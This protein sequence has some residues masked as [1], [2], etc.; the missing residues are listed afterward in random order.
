MAGELEQFNSVSTG[1]RELVDLQRQSLMEMKEI[2]QETKIQRITSEQRG[3][4]ALIAGATPLSG[5][6]FVPY[7]AYASDGVNFTPMPF[8]GA[9]QAM[10]N[11]ANAAGQQA[12][13]SFAD[14]LNIDST[15]TS[16]HMAT[17]M[18][19][20]RGQDLTNA[21]L[22]AGGAAF[23]SLAEMAGYA[24]GGGAGPI[25]S[26]IL[27][28]VGGAVVGGLAR[29]GVKNFL[30][31]YNQ[32]ANANKFLFSEGY[33]FISPYDSAFGRAGFSYNERRNLSRYIASLDV[34]NDLT[35][36]EIQDLLSNFSE[37][38]LLRSVSDLN[39]F[40]K[41]VDDLIQAT[42]ASA[43]ILNET[44]ENINGF[45]GEM[46]RMGFN[47]ARNFTSLT[48]FSR[49]VGAYTGR[50][51]G[52]Q[53]QILMNQTSG[54][55][56]GGSGS[57][58]QAFYLAGL[59]N[60]YFS[61]R[62]DALG[63]M[64]SPQYNW[65]QNNG[66]VTGMVDLMSQMSRT[67]VQ[68]PVFQT[69]AAAVAKY[70]NGLLTLDPS[71]VSKY[72]SAL[73]SGQMSINQ[74]GE[75]GRSR[76]MS[77]KDFQAAITRSIANGTLYNDIYSYDMA[78][79]NALISS[80]VSAQIANTGSVS[81]AM[82]SLGISSYG[83]AAEEEF[84]KYIGSITPEAVRSAGIASKL[85]ASAMETA[86]KYRN[87]SSQ[88]T[89][90]WNE[91]G[92]AI[93]FGG[94]AVAATT[95]Y[96]SRQFQK[97]RDISSML[98][99]AVDTSD[100]AFNARERIAESYLSGSTGIDILMTPE[101][102]FNY[103]AEFMVGDLLMKEIVDGN[104][105]IMNLSDTALSYIADRGD[106][107]K[108]YSGSHSG[109][110]RLKHVEKEYNKQIEAALKRAEKSKTKEEMKKH[111]AYAASLMYEKDLVFQDASAMQK[112]IAQTYAMADALI[113]DASVGLFKRWGM[114]RAMNSPGINGVDLSIGTALNRAEAGNM[115]IGE[116]SLFAEKYGDTYQYLKESLRIQDAQIE[117]MLYSRIGA[118]AFTSLEEEARQK[119]LS[120]S[121]ALR[122][123]VNTAAESTAV[124]FATGT[125]GNIATGDA[126]KGSTD[127]LENIAKES[128]ISNELLI[129]ILE[130]FERRTAIIDEYLRGEMMK[131]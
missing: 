71:L 29:Y 2:N 60:Q 47:V 56:Q 65:M 6:S 75:I 95:N 26:F 44:Y 124:P 131:N 99:A 88:I 58:E 3:I 21:V 104:R 114:R 4:G 7:S 39:S 20:N 38:R 18:R 59:A 68:S 52:E 46:E 36:G 97:S 28:S 15:R 126:D 91:I 82:Q 41:R 49:S 42:K 107:E 61:R 10:L 12:Y 103:R 76:M 14:V 92:Q 13:T 78:S 98:S 8:T 84:L 79:T 69:I 16:A 108:Q 111:E 122:Y 17:L 24:V 5:T 105:P 72:A 73:S 118:E 33:R 35:G 70:E 37:Q 74:I 45:M 87:F 30:N 117:K 109:R 66:G 19:M 40:K 102:L 129:R 25:G 63:A 51:G 80:V 53:M 43:M 94:S 64:N 127:T 93:G 119:G 125:T 112:K 121:E 57:Q 62:Y 81:A 9:T 50:N 32:A 89:H 23:S 120:G 110:A 67:A 27:G 85:E 101:E 100:D 55:L 77:N 34:R 54:I 96:G 48:A 22:N 1:I 90:L 116:L 83:G 31:E 86:A 130:S 11:T 113:K 128:E 123:I 106:E 115:S